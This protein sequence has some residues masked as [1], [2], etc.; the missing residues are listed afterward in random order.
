[1][2]IYSTYICNCALNSCLTEVNKVHVWVLGLI[3]GF[4]KFKLNLVIKVFHKVP[5]LS[6]GLSALDQHMRIMCSSKKYQ[7]PT[8]GRRLLEI[9]NN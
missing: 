7:L 2:N 9:P 3:C 5:G 4:V 1:M 8:P 6:I